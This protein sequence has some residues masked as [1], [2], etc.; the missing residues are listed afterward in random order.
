MEDQVFAYMLPDACRAARASRSSLY[1]AIRAGELVA[2]KR[3][4]RTVI[5]R[6]DLVSWLSGLPRIAA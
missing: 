5:L 2:R 3:G 6:D 1:R 4:R